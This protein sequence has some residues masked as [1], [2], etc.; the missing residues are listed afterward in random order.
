MTDYYC[1]KCKGKI[2]INHSC[3]LD[4]S[5][6]DKSVTYVVCG[7]VCAH[8]SKHT[9]IGCNKEFEIRKF[10]SEEVKDSVCCHCGTKI[11]LWGQAGQ[12]WNKLLSRSSMKEINF[13][14]NWHVDALI[15]CV[16]CG[17]FFEV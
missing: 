4:E 3:T 13:I 14:F 1:K 9:C 6:N 16:K 15:K 17:N 8:P 7:I 11:I 10:K 12:D 2:N 5:W